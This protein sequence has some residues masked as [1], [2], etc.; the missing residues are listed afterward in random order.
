MNFWDNIKLNSARLRY[1]TWNRTKLW[2]IFEATT[3]HEVQ[4]QNGGV[5]DATNLDSVSVC[6]VRYLHN[7]SVG[8]GLPQLNILED[9]VH[10]PTCCWGSCCTGPRTAPGSSWRCRTPPGYTW[11]R[12]YNTMNNPNPWLILWFFGNAKALVLQRR[13]IKKHFYVFNRCGAK[14]STA[15]P[16]V[17]TVQVKFWKLNMFFYW[18]ISTCTGT[19]LPVFIRYRNLCK[20]SVPSVK[21]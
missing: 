9:C 2:V 16:C 3:I 19:Y 14:D 4:R 20:V 6:V 5:D 10:V 8:A 18:L 15:T 7:F 21:Q 1:T 12:M 11:T 17:P 13:L